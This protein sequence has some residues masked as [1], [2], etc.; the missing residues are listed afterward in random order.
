MS[1]EKVVIRRIHLK[2]VNNTRDLGGFKTVDGRRIKPH[3]LIRSGEL[4]N[5]TKNDVR[6]LKEEYHLKKV[7][8]LRTVVER[9]RKKDPA[10][11]GVKYEH[12]PFVDESVIGITRDRSIVASAIKLIKSMDQSASEYMMGMYRALVIKESSIESV[13]RFF[14]ILLENENGAVLFHCS[15]GKDRV[16]A[17]TAILLT[18]LGVPRHVI[19]KDYM[20]TEK[21]GDKFNKKYVAAARILFKN[22][23]VS[24]YCE[25]FLSTNKNFLVAMFDEIESNYSSVSEYAEKCLGLDK[26][27]QEKLRSMYLY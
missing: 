12:V 2:G 8:D 23:K 5:I 6:I 20:A 27:K 3:R 10:I 13:K 18:I 17:A 25:V 7:I 15:A 22:K 19:I 9:E 1:K 4:K 21:F 11:A 24:E 16:G 26:E 14:E